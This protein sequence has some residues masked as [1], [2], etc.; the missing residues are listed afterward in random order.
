MDGWIFS[1]ICPLVYCFVWLAIFCIPPIHSYIETLIR[2]ERLF[3][4]GSFSLEKFTFEVNGKAVCE[5]GI[6]HQ[7]VELLIKKFFFFLKRKFCKRSKNTNNFQYKIV[8]PM[9]K[10]LFYCCL[11]TILRWRLGPLLPDTSSLNE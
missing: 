6:F 4:F 3:R 1:N 9:M 7:M 5:V 8:S 10:K 2:Y 11:F